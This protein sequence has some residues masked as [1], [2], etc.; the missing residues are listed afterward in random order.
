MNP[1][2]HHRPISTRSTERLPQGLSRGVVSTQRLA[3]QGAHGGITKG[4]TGTNTKRWRDSVRDLGQTALFARLAKG[5][6]G[7]RS[8]GL[9]APSFEGAPRAG[10]LARIFS[11]NTSSEVGL[12]RFGPN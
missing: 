7:G 3:D 12:V 9:K 4:Q 5:E 8:T 10:G 2:R 6:G 1:M 11:L